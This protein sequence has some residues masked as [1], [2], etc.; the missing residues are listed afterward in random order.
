VEFFAHSLEGEPVEKWQ[1]L[2]EH[3]R[4]VAQLAAKFSNDA[5]ITFCD[6][7]RSF[8]LGH[9]HPAAPSQTRHGRRFVT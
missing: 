2:E 3:M 8:A 7:G 4:N 5:S 1:R 6:H 9:S